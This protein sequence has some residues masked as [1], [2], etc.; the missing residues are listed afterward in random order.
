MSCWRNLDI[1]QRLSGNNAKQEIL[2]TQRRRRRLS[3]KRFSSTIRMSHDEE[4]ASDIPLEPQ[5][6]RAPRHW[7]HPLVRPFIGSHTIY[8]FRKKLQS[9][10][11][12]STNRTD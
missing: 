4:R 8:S 1:G 12:E 2:E 3:A 11:V 10:L 6:H 5:R 7:L 9:E